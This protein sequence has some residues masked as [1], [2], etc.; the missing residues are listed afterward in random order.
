MFT[1]SLKLKP[2]PG[3]YADYKKAHDELWPELAASMKQCQVSMSIGW[4]G[5]S[6]FLFAAAPT[7]ADWLRSRQDRVLERWN[8]LMTQFLETDATGAIAF[9]QLEKAFGFGEFQ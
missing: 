5:E 8:S 2:K 9:E 4:D 1:T 3:Q 6:L 7:E